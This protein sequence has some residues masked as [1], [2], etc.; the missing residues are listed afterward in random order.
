MHTKEIIDQK[1]RQIIFLLILCLSFMLIAKYL[2]FMLSAFLGAVSL[3]VILRIPHK[4]LLRKYKF[5]NQKSTILL[6]LLSAVLILLPIYFIGNFLAHKIIPY[7]NNPVP[8]V[9]ALH[10][11]N[12]YINQYVEFSFVSTQNLNKIGQIIQAFVPEL[13]NY[14]LNLLSN[15]VVMYFL[16]WFM[17]NK[18]FEME[19]WLKSNSPFSTKNHRKIIE[20]IKTSIFS[21]GVGIIIL[22]LI[23]GIV[24]IIGYYI[25][26]LD[27]PILWGL[28]TG[29]ASVI[30]FVG[31]MLVWVPL[32]IL[33]MANGQ[34]NAGLGLFF[35]GLLII[36]SSDNVFRFILQ[37]RLASTHP[38][39]T[40]LGVIIGLSFLGFWG[41]IFG[42]LLISLSLLLAKIYKEE[43]IL[44]S[45][46]KNPN[47]GS[48]FL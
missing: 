30:P 45:K 27:E 21:N 36:G 25:F 14:S 28:I 23:Q 47:K 8:I 12:T 18:S 41:L 31:T 11:I 33:M 24:A 9:D 40:V 10:S 44:P 2:L 15:T 4:V 6:L 42:P 26:G 48:S 7:F 34:L 13:L 17:L 16:L 1:L 29:A 46:K 32:S 39:I 20:H 5:G 19:L 3:Y 35:Y 22:G 38:I 43:F 37:K